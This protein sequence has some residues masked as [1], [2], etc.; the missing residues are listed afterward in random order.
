[1]ID[2]DDDDDDGNNNDD[3]KISLNRFSAPNGNLSFAISRTHSL[4]KYIL[5]YIFRNSV[6]PV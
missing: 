2:D 5:S 3:L 1:M 4:L 6:F